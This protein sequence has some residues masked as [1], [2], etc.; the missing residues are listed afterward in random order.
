[1]EM[2]G[3]RSSF[4]WSNKD[5]GLM[6]ESAYAVVSKTIGSNHRVG[7]SP[8]QATRSLQPSVFPKNQCKRFPRAVSRGRG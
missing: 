5:V 7:S 4:L 6:A 8:T 2:T 3:L 1:M